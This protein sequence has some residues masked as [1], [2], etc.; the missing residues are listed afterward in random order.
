V[1][2]TS[3]VKSGDIDKSNDKNFDK[4]NSQTVDDEDSTSDDD[5][6]SD[7]NYQDDFNESP[8]LFLH[9]WG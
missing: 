5:I 9:S 1:S 2:E 8:R 4:A 7:D 3:Q 6:P